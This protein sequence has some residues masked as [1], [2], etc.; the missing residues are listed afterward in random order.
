MN[1]PV[2]QPA[3]LDALSEKWEPLL[4]VGKC[5][6]S[7]Q[8]PAKLH[9]VNA[10]D[11]YRSEHKEP[12]AIIDK[13]LYPGL[14]LVAGRPKVGKSWIGMQIALAVANNSKF[15]GRLSTKRPGKVLYL[16]LEESQRRTAPRL[17]KLTKQT[18][19]LK[20]I[21]FVYEINPLMSGGAAQIDACLT[22]SPCAL[23]I[24]DTFFAISR[25][26]D[27]KNVDLLQ[28]EYTAVNTLRQIA[29]KHSCAILLIHHTRKAVGEGVD[30]VLGTSGMTAAPDAIWTLRRQPDGDSLLTVTGRDIEEVVYGM[31]LE[32]GDPF[33]WKIT[34]QGAE[35][36]LSAER[37]DIMELLRNEGP[38][39]PKMIA[40]ML[41]KN[42][43]TVRRLLQM[44]VSDGMIDKDGSTYKVS[45]YTH[46]HEQHEQ[47]ER[48][49]Q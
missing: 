16:A 18:D 11:V 21:Q 25:Q 40:S 38:Q 45:P 19:N 8:G 44:L 28:A 32:N 31:R 1:H 34:G 42:A 26:S 49:E 33:G 41:R 47:R 3:E 24:I 43:S 37:R 48:Y 35:A 17:R 10:V 27:R 12:E 4:D 5:E 46:S 39:V 30:T 15:A 29:E 7:R 36:E 14:S 13:L 23:V 9:L 20:N 2:A 22:E 6:D